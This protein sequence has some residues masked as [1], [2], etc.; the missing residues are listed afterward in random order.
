MGRLHDIL[1]LSN[2]DRVTLQQKI[3]KGFISARALKRVEILLHSDAGYSVDQIAEMVSR[4]PGTVRNIRKRYLEE[5]VESAISERPRP[6]KPRILNSKDQ[7]LIASIACS[8][9]PVGRDRWTLKMIAGRFVE[10]S[11]HDS[12]SRQHV[13]RVL[14]KT[15]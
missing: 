4:H 7:T 1:I 8:D 2:A 15:N 9:P 11:N 10:L 14:K 6:G 13:G 3:D 5:G 12:I